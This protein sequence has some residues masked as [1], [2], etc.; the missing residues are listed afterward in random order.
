VGGGGEAAGCHRRRKEW[1]RRPPELTAGVL[2]C[3]CGVAPRVAW[4]DDVGVGGSFA[5]LL[6]LYS[7]ASHSSLRLLVCA[8]QTKHV[9][10]N[11]VF[12]FE[13][14]YLTRDGGTGGAGGAQAPPTAAAA[15]ESPLSLSSIFEKE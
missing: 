2:G 11:F 6:S 4:E 12:V 7:Y 14:V 13:E 15:M 3:G 8:G 5:L 9:N 10:E 1:L